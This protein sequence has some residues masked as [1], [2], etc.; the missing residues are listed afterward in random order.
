MTLKKWVHDPLVLGN[1]RFYFRVIET[2]GICYLPLVL[3][4]SGLTPGHTVDGCKIHFAPPKQPWN[5]LLI[6]LV[7]ASTN[8][9]FNHGLKV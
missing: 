6:P 3:K 8:N 2:P 5:G 7:N 1:D 4:G 9:A